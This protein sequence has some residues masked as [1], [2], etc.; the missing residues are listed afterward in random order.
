[1]YKA[2]TEA[3]GARYNALINKVVE[4]KSYDYEGYPITFNIG[5]N[6]MVNATEMAKPFGKNVGDWLRL[7]S[8]DEFVSTLSSDMGID[9]SQLVI[10]NKGR[11][12]NY[13]QGTWI[14]EDVA[15]EFARWL[16]PKFAIWCNR[17]IKELL[18]TGQTSLQSQPLSP[19]QQLLA[20]AQL[21]VEME[22]RQLEQE[23][24]QSIQEKRLGVTENRI[25]EIEN[26]IRDNGFFTVV[27]FSNIHHI[28]IGKKLAQRI[29][30]QCSAWCKRMGIL[31][32]KIKNSEYGAINTYPI[33][34]LRD[35]FKVNFPE[36][37][38]M[39]D[40]PSYWG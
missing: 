40:I 11:S 28:N 29:G 18:K 32:E 39:F 10:V 21:L 26:R 5:E 34:A 27:A 4:S 31:P 37:S 9:I 15:I 20:N 35:V 1:M 13:T 38:A 14:H 25:D 22:Q 30:K 33:Q 16:S 36:K 23:R 12:S 19:A 17:H 7:K 6:L 24:R 2:S 8:T 3:M